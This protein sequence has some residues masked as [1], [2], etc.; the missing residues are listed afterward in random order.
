MT[1]AYH[2]WDL[3]AD[4]HLWNCCTCNRRFLAR[5]ETFQGE[6]WSANCVHHKTAD[7]YTN[8]WAVGC[9]VVQTLDVTNPKRLTLSARGLSFHFKNDT[10]HSTLSH[11]VVIRSLQS[12]VTHI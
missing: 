3:A 7:T 6:H 4:T 10:K 9:E 8:R 5:V 2:A 12:H 11:D 1:Y